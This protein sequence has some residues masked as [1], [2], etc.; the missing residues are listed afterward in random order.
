MIFLLLSVV[1]FAQILPSNDSKTQDLRPKIHIFFVI[2]P[3]SHPLEQASPFSKF[4][5]LRVLF[6]VGFVNFGP[7][8]DL[9]KQDVIMSNFLFLVISLNHNRNIIISHVIDLNLLMIK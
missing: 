7:M 8:F 3:H 9:T 5:D 2:S 4:L 1:D 6:M